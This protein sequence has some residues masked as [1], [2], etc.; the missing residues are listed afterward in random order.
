MSLPQHHS[1]KYMKKSLAIRRAI[2]IVFIVLFVILVPI[3]LLY[4]QGYRY[5]FKRGRVQKTSILIISSLPKK[6]AI[7][8][9]NKLV[10]DDTTPARLERVLPGDYEIKLVKDGYHDW[11]KKLPAFENGTTFAEDVILWKKS[12]PLLLKSGQINGW[13]TSP[14]DKKIIMITDDNKII[15]L[16]IENKRIKNIDAL[17]GYQNLKILGWSN[18]S[19]KIII[20]GLTES[21]TEYLVVNI[22]DNPATI[23]Q[24]SSKYLPTSAN[25]LKWDTTSDNYIFSANDEGLWQTDLFR[26]DHNL[27]LADHLPQDFI[28]RGND[29]YFFEN[30][31]IYK[32]SFNDDEIEVFLNPDEVRSDNQPTGCQECSFVS[33]DQ[34]KIVLLDRENQNLFV[35]DPERKTPTVQSVAKDIYWLKNDTLLFYNDWEIWIYELN[36]KEPELI[37]RLGQP[38]KKAIWHPIGRHIIFVANDAIKVIELDNRELRNIIELIS[39][40]D[41]E[42]LTSDLKGEN[43]YFKGNLADR[44]NLFKL[45]IR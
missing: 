7:Y 1:Q 4:T 24:L 43:L 3:I 23:L 10:E 38:I 33:Q 45:E 31:T 20:S 35:I 42:Y 21:K 34:P 36:E 16:E 44:E 28:S 26:Q 40:D 11:S 17:E 32:K 9:N 29:I 6:A 15:Y 8:L 12:I 37:T 39:M 41:I 22:E 13:L 5:N 18:S 14:D 19:K 25:S 2:Y 30:D 27:I